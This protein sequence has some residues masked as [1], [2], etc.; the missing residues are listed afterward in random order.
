MQMQKMGGMREL[1][2][3]MPGMSEMVP[4]GEDPEAAMKRVQGIIDSMTKDERRDPDV[5]DTNRRRR[6]AAGSGTEA[7]EIEQFLGQFEQIRDLMRQMAKMPIWER[8]KRITGR[9]GQ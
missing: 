5:M 6:I 1:M 4:E 2:A 9:L 8:I 7:H 3:H